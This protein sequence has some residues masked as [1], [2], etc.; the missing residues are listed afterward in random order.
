MQKSKL[1]IALSDPGF[2]ARVLQEAKAMI[3]IEAEKN[4]REITLEKA[5]QAIILRERKRY[6]K[7]PLPM[8]ALIIF[9]EKKNFING[10]KLPR[11][12]RK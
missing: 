4:K 11:K 1:Q 10:K 5:K 3:A 9:P 8:K 6:I 12:N 2:I 7:N